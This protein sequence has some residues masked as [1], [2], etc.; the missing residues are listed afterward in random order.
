[1]KPT[2][3]VSIANIAFVIEEDAHKSL[4]AY[5]DELNSK[6]GQGT[7][8]KEVLQEIEFR[9]AELLSEK[10]GIVDSAAVEY[11][12]STL[13]YADDIQY[14]NTSSQSSSTAST[15]SE[16]KSETK[17]Q[18]S[19]STQDRKLYRNLQRRI[20]GGVCSGLASFFGREPALMRVIAVAI[21]I[22][23]AIL[24]KHN[25]YLVSLPFLI[26]LALWIIIPPA[27]TVEQKYKM[28][29]QANNVDDIRRNV[30]NGT[31]DRV[32]AENRRSSLSTVA[33]AL[34]LALGIIMIIMAASGLASIIAVIIGL[35]I[36]DVEA[37][38]GI[39]AFSHISLYLVLCLP[40]LLLFYWGIL[41]AFSLKTPRWRPGLIVFIMWIISCIVLVS[42]IARVAV[43]MHSDERR[44]KE[45][46]TLHDVSDTLK[47]ELIH[48]DKAYDYIYLE[49]N[50]SEY[51]LCTIK[52]RTVYIYPDIDIIRRSDVDKAEIRYESTLFN[53]P[54]STP[55]TSYTLSEDGKTLYISPVVLGKGMKFDQRNASVDIVLPED[56]VVQID[57]PIE[58]DFTSWRGY[59]NMRIIRF[60][61][62]MD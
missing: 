17:K 42:S 60:L 26:Y 19:D 8:A 44:Y 32:R 48:A 30:E 12:K 55:S 34:A 23:F 31:A 18:E 54:D 29:G 4:S 21:F 37:I 57:K 27:I 24:A 36:F 38:F 62:M 1:M 47:I 2:I 6:F 45:R 41:L 59:T 25:G 16:A 14:D 52:D 40:L 33:R 5:L 56:T 51:D 9:I 46:T 13:G 7:Y 49:A 35:N 3:Q 10:G 15:E 61:R 11:V 28:H 43:D 58:H 50:K 53:T 22:F 39:T 20:L